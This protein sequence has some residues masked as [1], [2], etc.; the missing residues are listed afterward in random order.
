[1][2][3][4]AAKSKQSLPRKHR[5]HLFSSQQHWAWYD[6]AFSSCLANIN[7]ETWFFDVRH[8]IVMKVITAYLSMANGTTGQ[9]EIPMASFGF[10][11][12]IARAA[13]ISFSPSKKYELHRDVLRRYTRRC[14][15][16]KIAIPRTFRKQVMAWWRQKMKAKTTF[17][18]TKSSHR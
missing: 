9:A 11:I 6:I 15:G 8:S 18:H 12:A 3:R 17:S 10:W 16:D 2:T 1:M 5:C 13:R 7:K 4:E 14:Q